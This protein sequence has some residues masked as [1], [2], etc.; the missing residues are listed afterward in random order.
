MCVLKY[1]LLLSGVISSSF[2]VNIL[3]F[4]PHLAGSHFRAYEELFKNLIVKENNVTIVSYYP[5]KT[6]LRNYTSLTLVPRKELLDT[7]SN[8]IV[9]P[10]NS[11]SRID[12]YTHIK[13]LV[14]FS[15]M[16]CRELARDPQ[17]EKFVSKNHVFDVVLTEI[18]N[19]ECYLE[20]L[21]V[22]GYKGPLIG[23]KILEIF[24][25]L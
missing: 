25:I 6:P 1:F 4:M 2:S 12:L 20:F 19:N 3:V 8:A 13:I 16:T 15:G 5:L 17:V 10:E 22:I 9:F 18:F 23:E 11:F 14:S 24:T 7:I 21:K